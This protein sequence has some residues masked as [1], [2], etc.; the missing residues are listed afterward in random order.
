MDEGKED[1]TGVQ[2]VDDGLVCRRKGMRQIRVRSF[3]TINR[4]PLCNWIIPSPLVGRVKRLGEFD[5]IVLKDGC[6]DT[7]GLYDRAEEMLK[8][9]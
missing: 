9:S 7:V 5:D 2:G 1:G 6:D 4:K 8:T 3:P